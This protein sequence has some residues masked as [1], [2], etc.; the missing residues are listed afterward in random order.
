MSHSAILR[1]LACVKDAWYSDAA[2]SAFWRRPSLSQS[3]KPDRSARPHGRVVR[4]V[5]EVTTVNDEARMTND[6][7][8]TKFRWPLFRGAHAASHA[9][10]GASPTTLFG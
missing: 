8:M 7:G 5:S 10:A 6:E 3:G 2:C 4:Q 9:V 1:I